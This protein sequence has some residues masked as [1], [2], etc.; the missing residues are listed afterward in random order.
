MNTTIQI[1]KETLERLKDQKRFPRE[2]YDVILTTMLDDLE[3]ET[4]SAEEIHD[5][6]ESLTQ[7]EQGQTYSIE[8]VSKEL[9]INL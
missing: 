8:A 2:S 7:I 6:K 9:G 5:I 3:D 1:K 4:L